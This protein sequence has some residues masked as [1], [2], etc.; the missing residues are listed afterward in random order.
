MKKADVVSTI[1]TIQIEV[2]PSMLEAIDRCA[3]K[4]H[5]SRENFILTACQHLIGQLDEQELERIYCERLNQ[6]EELEWAEASA[7]LAGNV[8]PKEVW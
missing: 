4:L 1:P 3:R 2:E 6:T 8:L 5:F 7:K